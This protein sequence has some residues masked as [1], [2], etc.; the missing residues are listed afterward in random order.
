M[1]PSASNFADFLEPRI[2]P[3]VLAMVDSWACTTFSSCEG[4]PARGHIPNSAAT[5]GIL[6]LDDH[7]LAQTT[8]LAER[9]R[10]DAVHAFTAVGIDAVTCEVDLATVESAAGS[11]PTVELWFV[12]DVHSALRWTRYFQQL[13]QA[14][15]EALGCLR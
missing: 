7:E 1:P 3:L 14:I 5:V 13:D 11:F 10:G 15:D 6:P 9:F 12:P 4:H 8:V 2:R